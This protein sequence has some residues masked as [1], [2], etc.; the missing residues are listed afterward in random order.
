MRNLPNNLILEGKDN[1]MDHEC[2]VRTVIR[3][4]QQPTEAQIR[5][6]EK[7]VS[8]PVVP[9][10][11]TPELTVEQYAEMARHSEPF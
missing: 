9:D 5:E 4:G 2:I 6:I 1:T 3:I 11:D 8:M 10:D 7:A